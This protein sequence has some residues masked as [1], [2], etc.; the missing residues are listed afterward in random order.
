MAVVRS[1][2]TDMDREMAKWEK[3][4]KYE[5][6]P[7]MLYRGVLRSD[8]VHDFETT[9]VENERHMSEM[10]NKG[11]VQSPADAKAVVDAQ[12]SMIA[13]AAAEN[14]AAAQKMS[15]KA[16]KELAMREAATHRH[17]TE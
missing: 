11:W 13:E 14:A 4:Y 8:G 10:V 16:R 7:K 12:E 5:P 6:F 3:P 15:A 1:G 17:I 2:E 9:I